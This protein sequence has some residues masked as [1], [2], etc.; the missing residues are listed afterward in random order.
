MVA[1]VNAGYVDLLLNWKASVDRL[2]LTNYVIVPNDL[3]AA[4]QLSFL[5][6][7]S[8]THPH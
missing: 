2:N 7:L 6:T 4:Q 8:H 1:L 3:K 5:G